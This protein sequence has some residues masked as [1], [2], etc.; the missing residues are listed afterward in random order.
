MSDVF[1]VLAAGPCGAPGDH[2]L[3]PLHSTHVSPDRELDAMLRS[4][5]PPAN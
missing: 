1:E 4:V 3:R 5:A 2:A